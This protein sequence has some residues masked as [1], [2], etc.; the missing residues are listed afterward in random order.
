MIWKRYTYLHDLAFTDIS[1][2]V[3]ELFNPVCGRRKARPWLQPQLPA[4]GPPRSRDNWQLHSCAYKAMSKGR[5][6]RGHRPRVTLRSN[7]GHIQLTMHPAPATC[8]RPPLQSR[9]QDIKKLRALLGVHRGGPQATGSGTARPQKHQE[10]LLLPKRH[11]SRWKREG[12]SWWAQRHPCPGGA[13]AAVTD[14]CGRGPQSLRAWRRVSLPG[15]MRWRMQRMRWTSPEWPGRARARRWNGSGA[16]WRQVARVA[17]KS[18]HL[19]RQTTCLW[20]K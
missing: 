14:L 6:C 11:F 2:Q 17:V 12:G 18:P 3:E 7:H 10:L 16:K 15:E 8:A 9:R 13:M 1:F 5:Q 4:L 20:L 19:L